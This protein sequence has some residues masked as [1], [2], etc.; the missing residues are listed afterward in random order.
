MAINKSA[1]KGIDLTALRRGRLSLEPT[2]TQGKYDNLSSQD[3]VEQS[4][5][6]EDSEFISDLEI[7]INNG[8][9]VDVQVIYLK[10]STRKIVVATIPIL[11]LNREDHN[12]RSVYSDEQLEE[13]FD[14]ICK[15]GQEK[16]IEVGYSKET[17]FVVLDGETRIRIAE[18]RGLQEI[19]ALIVPKFDLSDWMKKLHYSFRQNDKRKGTCDFDKGVA[20][21][22]ALDKGYSREQIAQTFGITLD[23]IRVLVPV[24][25]LPPLALRAMTKH[26]RIFSRHHMEHI[27]RLSLSDD[28]S[29]AELIEICAAR[30]KNGERVGV[31]LVE[32]L[33]SDKI[34][35]LEGSQKKTAAPEKTKPTKTFFSAGKGKEKVA[36]LTIGK[37]K[38]G[39]DTI[40][41]TSA[42]EDESFVREIIEL[43]EAKI[44][45]RGAK[46]VE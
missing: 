29:A 27:K 22:R 3:I 35:E 21:I 11:H 5:D 45:E 9:I 46:K 34:K 23:E 10:N 28:N 12:S 20:F 30:V 39:Q 40:T 32:K 43:V 38:Y 15:N 24:C 44:S 1:A 2:T 16:P 41:L 26:A 37:G 17:G 31:R 8:E 18:R 6:E 13:L 25:K 4:F 19:D 14:D 33:V 42:F 36:S 7:K